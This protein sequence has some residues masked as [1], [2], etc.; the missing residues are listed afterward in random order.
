MKIIFINFLN[1]VSFPLNIIPETFHITIHSLWF[2]LTI[3]IRP[4]LIIYRSSLVR[5]ISKISSKLYR[6]WNKRRNEK[7]SILIAYKFVVL[8]LHI[9]EST[10][11]LRLH[12]SHILM[13]QKS[14]LNLHRPENAFSDIIPVNHTD[15][16]K[17]ILEASAERPF[18]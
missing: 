6:I 17:D 2:T 18:H 1:F 15:K 8:Q 13:T 7:N 5:W 14:I 16:G 4:L 12:S 9:N 10:I 3:T 11:P